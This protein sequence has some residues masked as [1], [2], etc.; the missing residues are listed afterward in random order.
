MSVR[1]Q[2][3]QKGGF[4]F[5]FAIVVFSLVY[6]VLIAGAVN[7][8]IEDIDRFAFA[9][10]PIFGVYIIIMMSGLTVTIDAHSVRIRFG[11]GVFWKTYSLTDIS[12]CRP[13]RSGWWWGYG[14]RW[15]IRGWL[16]NIAGMDAVEVFFKSGKQIRIGTD[17]AEQLAAAINEA[18]NHVQ[19]A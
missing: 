5:Y 14:V 16:Y 2:H 4:W 10:I 9:V 8:P 11:P 7:R 15:Y 3:T 6:V 13:V 18:A 17:D 1:Y 12:E 19:S